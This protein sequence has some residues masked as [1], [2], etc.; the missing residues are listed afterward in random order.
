VRFGGKVYWWV[1]L[2]A[3]IGAKQYDAPGSY[4]T[5]Y[6]LKTSSSGEERVVSA[7][8]LCSVGVV[9]MFYI[10]S[11]IRTHERRL[12]IVCGI[13]AFRMTSSNSSPDEKSCACAYIAFLSGTFSCY[14]DSIQACSENSLDTGHF[15][16]C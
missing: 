5:T 10:E 13:N 7:P 6:G 8:A 2:R 3:A 4:T 14:A 15:T 1:D 9:I 12:F 11:H 16:F